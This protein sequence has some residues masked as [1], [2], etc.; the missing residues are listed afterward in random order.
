LVTAGGKATLV[1]RCP[2]CR[3]E[4]RYGKGA[5]DSEELAEL[6][7]RGFSDEWL[8]CQGDLPGNFWRVMLVEPRQ[9]GKQAPGKRGKG[10]EP[11]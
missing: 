6:R 3:Q 5:M 10:P 2:L 7:A 11:A 4:H 8:P 1:A 9:K